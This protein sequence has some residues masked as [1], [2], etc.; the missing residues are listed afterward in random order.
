MGS[1]AAKERWSPH[2]VRL[3]EMT[4]T[5]FL[6]VAAGEGGKIEGEYAYTSIQLKR[7]T[8]Q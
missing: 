8:L 7:I 1:V 4:Q 5:L 2:W 6:W 3:N